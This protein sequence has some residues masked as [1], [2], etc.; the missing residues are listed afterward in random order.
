VI[1]GR[2]EEEREL[3]KNM[4]REGEGSAV[5]DKGATTLTPIRAIRR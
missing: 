5:G 4:D 3:E 2:K 1:G